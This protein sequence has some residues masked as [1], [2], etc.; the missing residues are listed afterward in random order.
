MHASITSLVVL[1]ASCADRESAAGRSDAGPRIVSLHDVT[2][3]LVV[4]LEA[5]DRLV[6]VGEPVDVTPEVQRSVARIPR[7]AGLESILVHRPDVV[8]G[9]A[10]VA[11]REPELVERLRDRGVDIYLAD[12]A[13]LDDVYA[14]TRAVAARAGA[15][16][17]GERVVA[18]LRER[19]EPGRASAPSRRARVFVYDCCDPPFTAGGHT[20]LTDLIE[21]AGGHNVFADVATDWTTVSWEAVVMRRPEL[22]V[23]H[24]Y[25]YDGQG[26]V[27]DKRRMLAA[28]PSLAKLPTVVMPLGWSLGGL[29]SA[30]AL[31]KLRQVIPEVTR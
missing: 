8:I 5:T 11:E 23:I 24:A 28:I 17:A 27:A 12:P 21:R 1:L 9:L 7:V 3:E 10:V 20:V 29:R 31:A 13:T 15:A 4:A 6:G 25:Q 14:T 30:D 22:V 18:G 16:E 26:D 2:T 19:V